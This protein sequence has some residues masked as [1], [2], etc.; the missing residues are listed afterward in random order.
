MIRSKAQK[1]KIT[2]DARLREIMRKRERKLNE[3]YALKNIRIGYGA[4]RK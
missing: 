3:K 1:N 2:D 4:G